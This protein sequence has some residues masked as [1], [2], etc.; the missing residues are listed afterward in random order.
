MLTEN[1]RVR[2]I[3]FHSLTE[4]LDTTT[5]Q[6]RLVFHMFRALAKFERSPIRERTPSALTAACRAGRTGGRL[7]KIT[8][9][10]IE[11]AK[12][13]AWPIPTRS[14]PVTAAG[15]LRLPCPPRRRCPVSPLGKWRTGSI[16]AGIPQHCKA[17]RREG[18]GRGRPLRSTATVQHLDHAPNSLPRCWGFGQN[19]PLRRVAEGSQ[20]PDFLGSWGSE[21]V[22]RFQLKAATFSDLIPAIVPI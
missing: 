19:S 3:G 22:C 17:N 13:N 16:L 11:A 12:A 20:R 21:N 10:A 6:G 1:L 5:V 4:A 8:D 15:P 7:P 14:Y 9:N 2:G 18:N